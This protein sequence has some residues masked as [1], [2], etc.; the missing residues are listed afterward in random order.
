M[1][2]VNLVEPLSRLSGSKIRVIGQAFKQR[3]RSSFAKDVRIG[4]EICR[5]QV[6]QNGIMDQ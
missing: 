3:R 4:R 2:D 1:T 5:A 6:L